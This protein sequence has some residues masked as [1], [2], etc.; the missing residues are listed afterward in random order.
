MEKFNRDLANF[1][2]ELERK[3]G[4]R[5]LTKEVNLWLDAMAFQFLEE[6]QREII[7]TESVDTR[8]L[9]NSF[10]KGGEENV[11]IRNQVG[12][13]FEVGSNLEYA[14]YVNDGHMTV[15]DR[16]SFKLKD[17]RKARWVPG[18]WSGGRFKYD[19]NSKDGMLLKEKWVEGTHF[20]DNA[21]K[22]F[23][24]MVERSLERKLDKWLGGGR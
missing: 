21:V 20:Y 2:D 16:Y 5:G 9:L 17:G 12:L 10:Q 11:W 3:L 23:E 1:A 8:R 4:K 7:R 18:T 24:K 15:R 13:T 6:V 22:I 14:E 19:R